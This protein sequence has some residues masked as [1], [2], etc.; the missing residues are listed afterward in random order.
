MNLTNRDQGRWLYGLH[1]YTWIRGTPPI[2]Q[3]VWDRIRDAVKIVV[4]STI[5]STNQ[6]YSQHSRS[7]QRKVVQTS[8]GSRSHSLYYPGKLYSNT[9]GATTHCRDD[10]CWPYEYDIQ[11]RVQVQQ[12]QN[13]QRYIHRKTVE[14]V[15]VNNSDMYHIEIRTRRGS[16]STRP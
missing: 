3:R 9:N 15:S 14:E 2:L 12:R 5:S 16:I 6:T 11:Y 8:E 13:S 1:P 4:E 7:G 10:C